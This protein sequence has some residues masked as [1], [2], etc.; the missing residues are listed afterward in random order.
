MTANKEYVTFA[1]DGMK[2][3]QLGEVQKKIYKDN[4]GQSLMIHSVD[5][6]S[7]LKVDPLNFL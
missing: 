5:Q 4:L 6:Y 1:K 3:L 2:V 7:F